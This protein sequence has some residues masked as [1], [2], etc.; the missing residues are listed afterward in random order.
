[1]IDD[2]AKRPS[3][4]LPARSDSVWPRTTYAVARSTI[5]SPA[6]VSATASVDAIEAKAVG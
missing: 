4:G 3:T 6:M 2:S 1:M 5:P